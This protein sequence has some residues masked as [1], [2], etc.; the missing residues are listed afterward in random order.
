M[1]PIGRALRLQVFDGIDGDIGL[2]EASP[3]FKAGHC[4]GTAKNIYF[5]YIH[6]DRLGANLRIAKVF[7]SGNSQAVRLPK[8]FQLDVTEVNIFRK[9]GDIVLR[10]TKRSLVGALE[11]F[12]QL[13]GDFMVDGRD[14]S[15]PQERRGL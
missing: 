4:V 11:V 10:P 9:D 2:D 13:S 3:I 8:E 15:P 6:R 7:K 1:R 5:R 14:L 12:A